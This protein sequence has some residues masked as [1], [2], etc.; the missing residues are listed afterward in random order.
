MVERASEMRSGGT[1]SPTVDGPKF[2]AVA[3]RVAEL[4]IAALFI[5]AGVLKA[6]DPLGFANDIDNYKLLPWSF[7][8]RLAFFLPWLEVVCG[9]TILARRYYHGSLSILILLVGVFIT[10]SIIAKVRGIDVSCGCFGH[11]GRD[12]S[13]AGHLGLDLAILVA[14]VLV[15]RW[16][17]RARNNAVRA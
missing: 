4:L 8:V 6:Y 2:R 14:L 16:R 12:L 3:V 1:V 11:A 10:A 9:L 7:G 17:F 13:F 5:Y 15:W